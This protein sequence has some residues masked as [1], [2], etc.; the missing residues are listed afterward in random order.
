MLT[1][2]RRWIVRRT[3]DLSLAVAPRLSADAVAAIGAALARAGMHCP[4]VARY[5][6]ENMQALGVYS[7]EALR[8]Y[9]DWLG[10]HF[11]GALNA[12]RLARGWKSG[13]SP[14]FAAIAGEQ[15]E[16]DASVGVL[17]SAGGG[18]AVLIGPHICNYLVNLVRLSQELP[19]TVYLRYS[20]DA[21]RNRAKQLWY[22]V[23]GID[24][25][26]EPAGQGGRLGRLGRMADA[27][28]AGRVVFITPDLPQKR[29]RGVPVRFFDREIYL[30]GGAAALA[31]RTAA[32]LY[33][34]LA[35]TSGRRQVLLVRGPYADSSG[36]A[37][38]RRPVGGHASSRHV[39]LRQHL[40]WFADHLV[41]FLREQTP[42]WYMWGDKRWTR[43]FRGDERYAARL[44]T[45]GDD[46]P[47]AGVAGAS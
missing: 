3:T 34:L 16:L 9:F 28:R 4:V 45:A 2:L 13:P 29:D 6:A 31:L 46:L 19:L 1:A 10:V 14:E 18:G 7:P 39:E 12:L 44:A 38:A 37:G 33:I 30:P 20:K 36:Q 11:A 35:R 40:Q 42:L 47:D 41:G 26:C 27:V 22:H 32:P 43:V 15:V 5:V 17:K 21:G 23:G 24:F 25:I 8:S